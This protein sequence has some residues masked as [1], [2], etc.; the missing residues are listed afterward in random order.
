[1][2][3]SEPRSADLVLRQTTT[4]PPYASEKITELFWS[5]LQKRAGLRVVRA[6]ADAAKRS[7]ADPPPATL[8]AMAVNEAKRLKADAAMLGEVFVY[9]ERVGSRLGAN[10]PA[11]VGYEAKVVAADG[12]V[13]WVGNY[14]ERQRP[15]IE[16][17]LGFVQRWGAFVT[18]EELARYG[19]EQVLEQFPFGEEGTQ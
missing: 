18:A 2:S 16:D 17:M 13:L 3:V 7:N 9:Q 10:P 19:V 8:A 6:S 5:R 11:A 1:M 12:Q 14:Y 4:V 15:M